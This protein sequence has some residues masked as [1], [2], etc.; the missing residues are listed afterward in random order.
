MHHWEV[1]A[2]PS[3]RSKRFSNCRTVF[4]SSGSFGKAVMARSHSRASNAGDP[5][6]TAPAG[7][8]AADAALRV[9]HRVVVNGQMAGDAHLSGQQDIL[10]QNA[11]C[12]RGRSAR[13]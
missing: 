5:D 4:S 8:V 13:R 1:V 10:L 2:A 3:R 12:R 11:S 7:H 9:D 6:I